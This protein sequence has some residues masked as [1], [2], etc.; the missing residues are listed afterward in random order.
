MS[1][2]QCAPLKSSSQLTHNVHGPHDD[3]FYKFLSSLEDEYYALRSSG[4]SGEG[5]HAPGKR[6]G[7]GVSHDLPVHLGR[8][9][10]AEAAERRAQTQRSMGRGG[11]LGDGPRTT[12]SPREV[13]AEVRSIDILPALC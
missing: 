4:Y 11:R 13:A 8:A 3:K 2:L 10:A 6:V 9:K 5:F 1:S 7:H 12:K